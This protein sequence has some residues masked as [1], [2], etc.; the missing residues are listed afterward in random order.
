MKTCPEF[1]SLVW[2]DKRMQPRPKNEVVYFSV[3]TA[4]TKET[5][6]KNCPRFES[7]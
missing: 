3:E 5:N 6:L 4:E 2:Q 1:E 7:Q